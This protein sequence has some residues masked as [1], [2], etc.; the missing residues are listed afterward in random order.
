M[1]VTEDE[2][3]EIYCRLHARFSGEDNNRVVVLLEE[4]IEAERARRNTR[5]AAVMALSQPLPADVTDAF[6][7]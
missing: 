1:H 7:V 6:D 4:S 3:K 2:A 5:R